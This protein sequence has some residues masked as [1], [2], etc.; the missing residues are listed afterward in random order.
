MILKSLLLELEPKKSIL[1]MWEG[2]A[3]AFDR[4]DRWSDIDLMV[5]AKDGQAAR[6]AAE[7]EAALKKISP[8]SAKLAVHHPIWPDLIHTFYKLSG[9]DEFLLVDVGV[10]PQSSRNK[11]LEVEIHGRARIHFDKAGIC[12]PPRLDRKKFMSGLKER[13]TRLINTF[14]LFSNYVTKELN[15]KNYIEAQYNYFMT[16]NMLVEALRMK[17]NPYHF[18]FRGRYIHYELPP[19]VSGRLQTLF[20]VKDPADLSRKDARAR[21]WF[22]EVIKTIT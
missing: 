11:L 10:M 5:A 13:K 8:F 12:K 6:A 22:K 20:Y 4:V 14:E 9:A 21:R 16:L 1:A 18:D 7:V 3:A 19:L 17:H 15:R 2:G